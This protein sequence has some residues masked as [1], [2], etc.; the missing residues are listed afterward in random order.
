MFEKTPQVFYQVFYF[1]HVCL[2]IVEGGGGQNCL[3]HLHLLDFEKENYLL[4]LCSL[5]LSELTQ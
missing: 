3:Y 5:K 1:L 2:F 4:I